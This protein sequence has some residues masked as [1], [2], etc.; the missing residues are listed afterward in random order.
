MNDK[1]EKF[2]SGCKECQI[3][4]DKKVKEPIKSHEVPS[5][6]W[7]KVSVDLFGPMPSRNHIIVVQDMASRFP[8]AKIVSSTAAE[9]V[10]PTL[11]QI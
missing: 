7:K 9:K 1:V 3:F 11:A 2:L 6:C 10:L 5:D 8:T 4:T